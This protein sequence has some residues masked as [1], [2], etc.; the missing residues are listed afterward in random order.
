MGRVL[1]RVVAE[2]RLSEISCWAIS[3][4]LDHSSLQKTERLMQRC[5]EKSCR[6]SWSWWCWTTRCH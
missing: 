3:N 4:R 2:E 1:L 6:S 5:V